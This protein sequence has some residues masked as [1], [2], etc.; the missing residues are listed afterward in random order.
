MFKLIIMDV[1]MPIKNGWE[2]TEELNSLRE[3]GEIPEL[4]PILGHT[5]F[6]SERDLQRCID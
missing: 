4:C 2:S 1:D 5:A 6:T 3:S